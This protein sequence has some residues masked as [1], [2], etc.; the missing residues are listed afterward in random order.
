VVFSST[1]GTPGSVTDN[2]GGVYSASLTAGTVAGTA[3]VTV[4]VGGNAL[5]VTPATVILNGDSSDLS[6]SQSTLVAAPD[7][8]V[9]NNSDTSLVTLTLRDGHNNPVSGQ[10]VVFSSTLGSVGN[11]TEGADGVYRA[12]LSAGTVAGTASV[13]V[14]V[15][16]SALGVTPATVLLY[17]NLNLSPTNSTLMAS[18]DTLVANNN[19]TSMML[20]I[21]KD[22]NNNPV[23]GQT[24]TF[25]STLGSVGSVTE[26]GGGLYSAT[27]TA[28]SVAGTA[29]VSVNVNGSV[30][31]I[32]PATVVLNSIVLN[33]SPN[34]LGSGNIPSGY[35]LVVYTL[36]DGNWTSPLTLPSTGVSNGSTITITSSAG[37]YT[38][39]DT[40]NI[41]I[42]I[43]PFIIGKGTTYTF[44]YNSATQLWQLAP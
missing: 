17:P 26:N 28:G 36:S 29:R 32:T 3:S 21:L 41:N 9:A 16:G 27:L 22:S 30:F 1:L 34:A 8:L 40:S 10:T 42:G 23:T 19:D 43:N 6:S 31:N 14:N 2:G 12:S 18:P 7:T 11:V 25:A 20:L 37:Y 44:V 4:N 38:D 13:T 33:T 15:G 39:L 24:V 35:A 5:S